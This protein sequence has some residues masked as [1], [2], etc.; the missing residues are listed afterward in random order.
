MCTDRDGHFSSCSLFDC[1]TLSSEVKTTGAGLLAWA[2]LSPVAG[3]ARGG[4]R[5]LSSIDT[6]YIGL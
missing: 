3:A 2:C 5:G 6:L 1:M 4:L